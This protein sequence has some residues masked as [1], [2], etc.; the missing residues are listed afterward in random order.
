MGYEVPYSESKG[1]AVAITLM[2][3][4]CTNQTIVHY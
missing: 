2:L 3:I 4:L 1:V